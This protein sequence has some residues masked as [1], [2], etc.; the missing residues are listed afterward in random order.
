[1][2]RII[3]PSTN[4]AAGAFCISSFTPQGWRT[5]WMSK[6]L[7]RSKISLA[8][9]VGAPE[10]S[11]ASAQRRNRGYR[12][13]WPESR[14]LSSSPWERFSRLPRG[15]TRA[16]TNSETSLFT[17]YG[18]MSIGTSSGTSIQISTMSALETATQPSVQSC[19][20]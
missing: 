10:L 16:S 18:R 6:S 20:S 3:W 9:S 19:D 13:P 14:S 1:M 17:V 5:I 4:A 11:T 2:P 8:S 12:P 7:W 15:P